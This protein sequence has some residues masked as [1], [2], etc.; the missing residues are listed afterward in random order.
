MMAE[1]EV[2][3]FLEWKEVMERIIDVIRNREAE[4]IEIYDYFDAKTMNLI[5]FVVKIDGREQY[6]VTCK[7]FIEHINKGELSHPIRILRREQ[8]YNL[9]KAIVEAIKKL[10]LNY[11]VSFD[12]GGANVYK[13]AGNK[14]IWLAYANVYSESF[15][16]SEDKEYKVRKHV[17]LCKNYTFVPTTQN[18]KDYKNI[19]EIEKLVNEYLQKN[20]SKSL[21]S[22]LKNKA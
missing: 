19:K 6:V 17:I 15:V 9:E 3:T 1:K 10:N 13:K 18:V 5:K 21:E 2:K 8:Y 12:D 16:Q 11:Y 22:N 4:E 20:S 7:D 14:Y